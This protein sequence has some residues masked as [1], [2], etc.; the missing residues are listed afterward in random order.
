MEERFLTF[1]RFGNLE[2]ANTLVEVLKTNN[3]EYEVEDASPTFDI[4][5]SN[6]K[7]LN[8]YYVK[9]KQTDFE[10]TEKLLVDTSDI[11]IEDLPKDYYLFDFTDEELIEILIKPDEWN[12]VDYKLSQQILISRG[13]QID[14]EFISTLKKKRNEELSKPEKSN[15]SWRNAGYIFA[16]LGGL[17]GVFIGW[18]LAT[19][20][21]TLPNGERVYV[22][23]ESDRKHG[24]YILI[25]G[26][27]FFA[28]YYTLYWVDFFKQ[29]A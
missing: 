20:K 17:L 14:E 6:N 15:S 8:E 13:K 28:I 7:L 1:R 26:V 21:K 10:S 11:S 25:M 19:F 3:I 24:K 18:H 16:F 5:F 9:L 29:F 4:T 22:Y 23:S 27:I 12:A 2:D